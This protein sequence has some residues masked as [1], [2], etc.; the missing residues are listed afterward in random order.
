MSLNSIARGF[1]GNLCREDYIETAKNILGGCAERVMQFMRCFREYLPQREENAEHKESLRRS[2]IAMIPTTSQ[3]Q[4]NQIQRH[5]AT[6]SQSELERLQRDTIIDAA[7]LLKA[8]ALYKEIYVK[9]TSPGEK[10]SRV[11]A[12]R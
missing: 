12:E 6:L 7:P 8:A 2:I 11:A 9:D 3:E 5:L 4:R 10:R 1:L